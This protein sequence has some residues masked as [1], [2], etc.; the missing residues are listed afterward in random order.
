MIK[1]HNPLLASLFFNELINVPLLIFDHKNAVLMLMHEY[2][3]MESK[4]IINGILLMSFSK[5]DK[6]SWS[7]LENSLDRLDSSFEVL[8]E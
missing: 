1:Y 2:L 3:E 7:V 4:C 5:Q 6:K 8:L